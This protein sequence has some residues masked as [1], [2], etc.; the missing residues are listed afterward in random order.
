[1]ASVV[2][3]DSFWYPFVAKTQMQQVLASDWGRLFRNWEAVQADERGYADVGAE[4]PD[5][6]LSGWKA[7]RKSLGILAMC[8]REAPEFSN[9]HRKVV[10]S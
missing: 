4:A 3:H 6:Q 1:M 2:Y 10:S 8:V 5:L 7:F 9:R